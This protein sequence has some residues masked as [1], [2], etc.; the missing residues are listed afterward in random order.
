MNGKYPWSVSCSSA[1]SARFNGYIS[2]PARFFR[3]WLLTKRA[4]SKITVELQKIFSKVPDILGIH[5][6]LTLFFSITQFSRQS[7]YEISLIVS[8]LQVISILKS[9]FG[10]LNELKVFEI[11]TTAKQL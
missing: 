8:K 7:G 3:K 2:F 1:C 6:L 11:P 4:L 10:I 9:A 5:E